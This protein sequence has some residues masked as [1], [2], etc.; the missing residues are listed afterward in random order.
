VERLSRALALY[1]VSRVL[2]ASGLTMLR[3]SLLWHLY[4]LTKSPLDLGLVG[5]VQLVP[6]LLLSLP[7]GVVADRFSRKRIAQ[8]GQLGAALACIAVALGTHAEQTRALHLFAVAAVVAAAS[9]FAN[10]A[11]AALLPSLVTREQ[12]PRA[13]TWSSTAQALAFATGPALA[14]LL[15]ASASIAAAYA[16]AAILLVGSIGALAF[17]RTAST[18]A[19][20][21]R[22]ALSWSAVLDGL[23][24]VA[25]SRVV[26]GAMSLDLLAVIFGGAGALLPVF[27]SD[28]LHVGAR[29][30]GALS[31]SA[32]VGAVAMSIVL[33]ALP[34]IRRAGPAL[35]TAVACYGA[36]TI[37]F[38]ASTAFPL[39]LVAYGLVGA[40][41]QVSVVLRQ[42]LVQLNTPDE[43]RGRVS[44][45]SSIFIGA[46]NQLAA[47][48]AGF[49]AAATT[50]PFA[51]VSGGVGV[52]VV[53]AIVAVAL[54]ELRRITIEH[55]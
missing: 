49:V 38:G 39:S 23:R 8:L 53:V 13:V 42:T 31:A 32:E 37:A 14:G 19:G 18:D 50:A 12:F 11:C 20:A 28:V 41:D 21:T 30:Y 54:P 51:V 55:S 33:V 17:L 7:A 35:L 16:G 5:L 29:G 1:L 34:P 47:V 15:L 43:L 36:C 48:E 10:P 22:A 3:A 4:E 52:L 26:L 27:A 2:A 45:V 44:S 24:F 40:A 25:K 9:A 46:S 6:A